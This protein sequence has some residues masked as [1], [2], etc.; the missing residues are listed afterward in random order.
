MHYFFIALILIAATASYGQV[1]DRRAV[2]ETRSGIH[3]TV[4]PDEKLWLVSKT[5][6]IFYCNNIDS[7]WHYNP[8][9]SNT[10]AW[11]AID[12]PVF[13]RVSF[14][15]KDTAIITGY[16]SAVQGSSD[17][18]GYFLTRDGGRTWQRLNYGG[19]SWIYTAFNEQSGNAW[20]GG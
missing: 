20:L 15:N 1:K 18:D 16:I 5:G 19:Y 9:F 6:G 12:N 4:G 13:D 11:F 7:G 14:F 8:H 10:T 17:K 2:L 3:L